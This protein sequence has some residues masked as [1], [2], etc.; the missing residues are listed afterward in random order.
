MGFSVNQNNSWESLLTSNCAPVIPAAKGTKKYSCPLFLCD[1]YL[2]Y[3]LQMKTVSAL[4]QA[5]DTA[6]GEYEEVAG[7]DSLVSTSPPEPQGQGHCL[8]P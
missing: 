8:L 2:Q 5:V 3:S 6:V 7:E 4:L 1:N